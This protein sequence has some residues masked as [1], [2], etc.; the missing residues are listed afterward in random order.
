MTNFP[1]TQ[2]IETKYVLPEIISLLSVEDFP[3]SMCQSQ[4]KSSSVSYEHA[5][6]ARLTGKEKDE[7]IEGVNRLTDFNA[8]LRVNYSFL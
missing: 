2:G 1:R 7:E 8:L 4:T 3:K 5:L 6:P